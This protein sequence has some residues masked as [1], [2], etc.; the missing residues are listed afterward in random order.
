MQ[1]HDA[2]DERHDEANG[3]QHVVDDEVHGVGLPAVAPRLAGMQR[4]QLLHRNEDGDEHH[5]A[6]HDSRPH[7]E[8]EEENEVTSPG[9]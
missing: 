5:D 9:R 2:D 1:R 3:D 6:E 7:G 8:R 4:E